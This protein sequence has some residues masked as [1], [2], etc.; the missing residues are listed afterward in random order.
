[1]K[2]TKFQSFIFIFI[3]FVLGFSEFIIVG[4]LNDIAGNLHVSIELVGYLVT[5]FALVYAICTP[6]VTLLIGKHSLYWALV[7][8]MGIFILGNLLTAIAN[9]YGL[10]VIAR[11]LTASVSGAAVSVVMAIS[12]LVIPIE[13]R[14]W[15]VSWIYSGFSIASVFGVPVGT[16]LSINYGWRMAFYIILALSIIATALMMISLPKNLYQ[17]A[18]G[19]LRDQLNI[20]MDKR[21][22]ISI[23]LPLFTLAGVYV[24]YTYLRPILSTKLGFNSGMVTILLF[25]YGL[26]SL[27]SNQLSGKVANHSGLKSMPVTFLSEFILLLILPLMM[28]FNWLSLVVIL[29]LGV[30][31]YIQNSP[32]QMFFLQV[33]EKDYPQSLVLASSLNSIFANFGIAVGSATG[34]IVVSHLGLTGV[35]P[36]GAIYALISVFLFMVL[37]KINKQDEIE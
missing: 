4:I 9:N 26:M 20:L 7:A 27:I 3:A 6:F 16:W 33:A 21:I 31:M 28:N 11:I 25:A 1:M 22:L 23:W 18:T 19:H 24:F 15:I 13:R 8:L 29:L 36:I 2:S 34:G 14:A 10:L 35:G 5:I 37:I 12:M 17:K 30:F 32:L